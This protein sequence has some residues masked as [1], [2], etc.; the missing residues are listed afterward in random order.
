MDLRSRSVSRCCLAAALL[1][2]GA[3]LAGVAIA[4]PAPGARTAE[5]APGKLITPP[6][7]KAAVTAPAPAEPEAPAD[8]ALARRQRKAREDFGRGLML[9][10]QGAYAAAILSYTNAAK[11]DPTLRGPSYRIGL[12]YASR[13]QHDPAMRAFREELRRS[14]DDVGA[15]MEYAISLAELGD[16]T[17]SVRMLEEL[18]RRAPANPSVWRSLGFVYGRFGR[19]AAAEKA[20]RGAVGLDAKFARAW[21]DLGVI[22]AARE[23][24][25]EARDAYRRALQL[26]PRD[27]T[28][29]INLANLESRVGDH[30]RALQG[31]REAARIDSLQAMAYRGQIRELVAMGRTDEAGGVWRRWLAVAPDAPEVREGAARHF[32]HSGRVDIALELAR[33]GVRRMPKSGDAWWL[34]GEMQAQ[35][36]DLRSALASYRRSERSFSK[37]DERLLPLQSIAA[38]HANAPDSLRDVFRA[39]SLEAVLAR[40][41]ADAT[42]RG[43]KPE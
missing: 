26:E 25:A 18:S 27:E 41:R 32:V 29:L 35:G 23:R 7:A 17:R 16:S 19:Y 15:R 33:D 4:A 14:P 9:E 10:E 28:A 43:A 8:T 39:D 5:S 12:L 13:Q 42:R 31:Y 11:A 3:L 20:L 34:L 24:P 1:W 30:E 38:L 36:G 6:R 21:R 22:L 37:P 40:A 2:C